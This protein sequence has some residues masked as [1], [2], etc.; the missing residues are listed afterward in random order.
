[1]SISLIGWL[2][3]LVAGLLAWRLARSWF[4]A[5]GERLVTCPENHSPAG[6]SLQAGRAMLTGV[7][8]APELRLS[9][10]SRW[11]EKAGCG[12]ECVSQ[13]REAGAD[14]LVRNIIANWYRDR[15]CAACGQP[16]GPIDWT[17]SHPALRIGNQVSVEWNQIPAD[18]LT[19]TLES[20]SALCFACHTAN[21]MV[22]DHP[23]LVIDRHRPGIST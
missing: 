9:E 20:A 6:V 11:P 5:R 21:R 13:I 2:V 10:C 18:K 8:S 4:K 19:V 7:G 14:C 1:M 22:H 17:G 23:E 3:V 12:Q 15:D 16:I